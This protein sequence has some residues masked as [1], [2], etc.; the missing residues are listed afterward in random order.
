MPPLS[1]SSSSV[2]VALGMAM[3]RSTTSAAA[4]TRTPSEERSEFGTDP[5]VA[6][7]FRDPPGQGATSAT[8]QEGSTEINESR[9]A[10]RDL[11]LR[12][13]KAEVDELFREHQNLAIKS[14]EEGLTRSE[15][16]RLTMVRWH[17]A[18]IQDAQQGGRLDA[19][20][21]LVEANEFLADRVAA[22]VERLARYLDSEAEDEDSA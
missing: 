13:P 6:R 5:G 8:R 17:I 10:A 2:W 9:R 22:T 7:V 11:A 15:G 4:L 19:L 20:E 3:S 16:L 18:R 1:I 12:T 21:H 14:I